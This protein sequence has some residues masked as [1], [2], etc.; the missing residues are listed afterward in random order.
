MPWPSGKGAPRALTPTLRTAI[1]QG[2]AKPKSEPDRN[3]KPDP[4]PN[5]TLIHTQTLVTCL[6][7]DVER[8]SQ[9][10]SSI[11]AIAASNP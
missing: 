1:G 8:A 4:D 6:D 10:S 9:S 7:A 11:E 3:P 2:D 5:E